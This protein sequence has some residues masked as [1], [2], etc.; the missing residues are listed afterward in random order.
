MKPIRFRG[1][2]FN[3]QYPESREWAELKPTQGNWPTGK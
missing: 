2:G 3:G 1:G